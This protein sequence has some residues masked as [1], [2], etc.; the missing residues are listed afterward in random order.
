MG[1]RFRLQGQ[2]AAYA[3]WKSRLKYEVLVNFAGEERNKTANTPENK[4]RQ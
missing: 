3:L 4:E 2:S 1:E